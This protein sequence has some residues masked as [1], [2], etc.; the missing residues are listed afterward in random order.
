M[1]I[2]EIIGAEFSESKSHS[3]DGISIR[4]PRVTKIR[5]DKTWQEATNLDELKTLFR[6]SKQHTDVKGFVCDCATSLYSY[7]LVCSISAVQKQND[8]SDAEDDPLNPADESGWCKFVL[9]V[10]ILYVCIAR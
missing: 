8:G 5:S 2:W 7:S 10:F 1:Q 4:F 3:A 6:V 9:N